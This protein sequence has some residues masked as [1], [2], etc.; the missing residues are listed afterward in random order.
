MQK[1]QIFYG[2]PVTFVFICFW[3]VVVKNGFRLLYHETLKSTII[4]LKNELEKSGEFLNA[5]TNLEK[6]NV[7]LIIIGWVCSKMGEIF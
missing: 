1:I 6:L 2:G 4:Y 3:V 5:E 7:N